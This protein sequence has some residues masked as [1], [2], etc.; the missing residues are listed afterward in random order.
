MPIPSSPLCA[1]TRRHPLPRLLLLATLCAG[2]GA[3]TTVVVPCAADNTLYYH[4]QGELSNGGGQGLFVGI[5]GLGL[6]LRT[7][8]RF[9][10]AA[11][12]PAGASIVAAKL[13]VRSQKSQYLSPLEVTAH[14]VLQ[15]WGEGAS[16]APSGGGYGGQAQANDATWL[17][18]F[19][20]TMFWT[21]PGGDFA[22]LPSTAFAIPSVGTA[23]SPDGPGT[24]AD[25]QAW[26][27]QPG[28]NFGWLLKTDE[29]V[30]GPTAHRLASR[31]ASSG[32]PTLTVTYLLAGETGTW[33]SGCP[34]ANG[35]FTFA[36]VGGMTGGG[37]IQF[38][39]TDGPP[40]T[41]GVNYFALDLHQPGG[42][43]APSCSL[44]LPITQNWIPGEIFVLDAAGAATFA[45][46]V[47]SIYPGLYFVTQSA[48]LDG[49]PFGLA[50]SNAGV[51]KI[52]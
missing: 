23:S 45:W 47:P 24:V 21:T 44:Y 36:Y 19:Y 49:S 18:T 51:G 3:Q 41:I 7:V 30:F 37:T 6:T 13:T 34:T 26:L 48:A 1:P 15:A 39:H 14:R 4:A 28:Q 22:A 42:L 38:A 46:P 33:G 9:D 29:T 25:V 40:S 27:D 17:H 35:T 10:V 16:V 20:P 50:L 2:L 12:V 5:N 52:L 32:R 31:T 8:L 43:L 11:A